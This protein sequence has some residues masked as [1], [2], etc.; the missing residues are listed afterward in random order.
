[1][2]ER[3][4][5]LER[6]AA[7]VLVAVRESHS[8]S[9]KPDR[10]GPARPAPHHGHDWFQVRARVGV[11]DLDRLDEAVLATAAGP[12]DESYR[13]AEGAIA[14]VRARDLLGQSA[15]AASIDD[16]VE[17]DLW[18]ALGRYVRVVDVYDQDGVPDEVR[19]RIDGARHRVWV[20]SWPP[21]APICHTSS[22]STTCTRSSWSSTT[23]G[24]SSEA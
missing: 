15:S 11:A 4:E 21:C 23:V 14:R 18:D 7:K 12:T 24:H 3:P 17:R 9:T 20:W 22:S 5:W 8:G 19:R 1:M 16:P 6:M 13:M 2:G 10:R